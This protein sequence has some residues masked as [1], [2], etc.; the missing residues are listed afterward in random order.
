[1]AVEDVF[2]QPYNVVERAVGYADIPSDINKAYATHITN[3]G[4][5]SKQQGLFYDPV[6]VNRADIPNED[7]APAPKSVLAVLGFIALGII[8]WSIVR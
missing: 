8:V 2:G 7:A 5:T 6:S 3:D 4:G 1:M